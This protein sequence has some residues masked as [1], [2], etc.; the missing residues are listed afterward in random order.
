[1]NHVLPTCQIPA[2]SVVFDGIALHV[3]CNSFHDGCFTINRNLRK[4]SFSVRRNINC[5]WGR[6]R[7]ESMSL[8]GSL[9]WITLLRI[10]A[11]VWS[12]VAQRTS[13]A[14]QSDA[15]SG[16]EN[17]ALCSPIGCKRTQ[18]DCRSI[19]EGRIR[20]ANTAG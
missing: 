2:Q 20:R 8:L 19:Q 7:A 4:D 17:L 15:R 16:E 3:L 12:S 9:T 18:M 1:M 6:H 5:K 10:E 13:H 14:G 11:T